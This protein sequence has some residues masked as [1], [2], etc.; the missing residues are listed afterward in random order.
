[1]VVFGYLEKQ[2]QPL[3]LTR[4]QR[5]CP[6]SQGL[7]P[8]SAVSSLLEPL[9][10]VFVG[11]ARSLKNKETWKI[12]LHLLPNPTRFT[13]IHVRISVYNASSSYTEYIYIYT[14]IYIYI[15]YAHRL[16]TI[17]LSMLYTA[18]DGR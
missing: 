1:M 2:P 17:L 15:P 13:C 5:P 8:R 7:W 4:H 11:A 10:I 12:I 18:V 3:I 14:Y 16:N 9:P 6:L